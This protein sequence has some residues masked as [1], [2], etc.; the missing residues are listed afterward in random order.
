VIPIDGKVL[1]G[2]PFSI[3]YGI[4]FIICVVT[5]GILC[6]WCDSTVQPSDK[7]QDDEQ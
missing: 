3:G 6:G 2:P 5:S 7:P 1:D 4:G